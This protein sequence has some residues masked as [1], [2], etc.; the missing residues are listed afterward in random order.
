MEDQR[1]AV[2]LWKAKVPLK[3]VLKQA[4]G[5]Q[6][7]QFATA[8]AGVQVSMDTADGR[9][10]VSKEPRGVYAKEAGGCYPE[11]G[12]LHQVLASVYVHPKV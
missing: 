11:R 7:H 2:E 12:Q 10:P 1:V 8:P 6:S 5:L 4:P 9:H 3:Q